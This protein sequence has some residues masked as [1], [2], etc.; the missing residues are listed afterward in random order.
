MS[1]LKE[2][3]EKFIAEQ[4]LRDYINNMKLPLDTK[5]PAKSFTYGVLNDSTNNMTL[6]VLLMSKTVGVLGYAIYIPE[7][8]RMTIHDRNGDLLLISNRVEFKPLK[9]NLKPSGRF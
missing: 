6:F 7:R 1:E 9:N 3:D 2:I 5:I 8:N 4:I